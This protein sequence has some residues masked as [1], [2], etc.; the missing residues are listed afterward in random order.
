MSFAKQSVN[1]LALSKCY[2][3][4]DKPIHRLQQF[5]FS[6]F[7]RLLQLPKKSYYREFWALQDVTM[8]VKK[9]EVVGVIGRNGSGKSTLLQ[10]IA[11]TL[12]PTN[13]TVETHGR[14]TSLL[15]LGSGF[16]PEFTGREN[17][18]M[19]AALLGL[20]RDE[21]KLR[22]DAIV[23]F[24]D[25][26]EFINQP[27]KFYSSGMAVRL[28][29]AVQ[30]TIDPDILIVDEAL[31][32]GD[33]KFQ[34]KCFRRLEDLKNRG[35]SIILVSHSRETIVEMCDRAL[36]LEQGHRLLFSDPL[37]AINA[38][39]KIIYMNPPDREDFMQE[40]KNVDKGRETTHSIGTVTKSEQHVESEFVSEEFYES[41]LPL[42]T[43][44]YPSEGARIDSVRIYDE[45]GQEVD[46]LMQGNEYRFE[47]QGVFLQ[48]RDFVHIVLGIRSLDGITMTSVKYP[49]ND[50]LSVKK[51]QSFRL[52]HLWKINLVPG[53]YFSGGGI[54]SLSEPVLMHRVVDA[55]M[56]RV[57][58]RKKF[59]AFGYIDLSID[60][61]EFEIS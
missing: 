60:E 49:Y 61:P 53:T 48:E 47:M 40:L 58:P 15:E 10:I 3:V 38:Y 56:F 18:F 16:N 28:A 50:Y 17:V 5:V 43:E 33:E 55:V 45:S 39:Q 59:N 36:L 8:D 23:D 37:T 11:G 6:P 27:V 14:I 30:A 24:A 57:L 29:F 7:S 46:S 22:F 20:S 54:W 19:N 35:T 42:K 1:I 25:I 26:G 52:V 21:I 34:R 12:Y 41:S 31:A 44:V 4:Y 13:G 32:V 2:H 9:G 51:G